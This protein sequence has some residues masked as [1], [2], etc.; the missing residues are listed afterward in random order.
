VKIKK[1]VYIVMS[2]FK[3]SDSDSKHEKW[4]NPLP[5]PKK[6]KA[7]DITSDKT[8]R[9][10][11]A[12]IVALTF[13]GALGLFYVG[14]W[15]ASEIGEQIDT[16]SKKTAVLEKKVGQ[17]ND[18]K[19]STDDEIAVTANSAA[20]AGTK[21]AELQNRYSGYNLETQGDSVKENAK[22]LDKYFGENDKNA[23]TPWYAGS[24]AAVKWEFE[25]TYSFTGKTAD[26]IWLCKDGSGQLYA[27]VTAVYD[28]DSQTF[29]KVVRQYTAIGQT[30]VKATDEKKYKTKLDEIIK[31]IQKKKSSDT[32]ENKFTPEQQEEI[33]EARQKAREEEL[34]ANH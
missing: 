34:N 9:R 11:A 23:R 10:A 6:V 14:N 13:I 4:K 31:E 28:A 19:A 33:N 17:L 20:N 5:E 29:S 25:S 21:V 30:H 32:K 24:D 2:L 26:V 12:G 15:R 8:K 1:G 7:E 22:A 16:V 18:E 3:K 27:Y